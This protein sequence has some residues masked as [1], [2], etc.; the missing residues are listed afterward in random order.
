MEVPF[1]TTADAAEQ[2]VENWAASV[3]E[4]AAQAQA[5]SR[6]VAELSMTA[7]GAHGAVAVT[8]AGSGLV[9]DLRL[10]DRVRSWS[11][12][13]IAAEILS[14]MRRAQSQLAGQVAVIAARTVGADSETARAVVASFEQRFPAPAPDQPDRD[15]GRHG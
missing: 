3:N 11:G 13:R 6:Q 1:S 9:T 15:R 14:V 8:V 7:D 5:M 10:D 2:W 4:R 12:D